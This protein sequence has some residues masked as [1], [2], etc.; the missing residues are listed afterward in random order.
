[1][2]TYFR[3]R[4]G[5]L[6]SVMG[7]SSLTIRLVCGWGNFKPLSLVTYQVNSK[8]NKIEKL[9]IYIGGKLP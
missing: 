9:I 1:M 3:I 4:L 8:Y 2:Y 5:T 6:N 7:Y